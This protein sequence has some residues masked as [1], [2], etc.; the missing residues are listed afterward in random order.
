MKVN[1]LQMYAY[2]AMMCGYNIFISGG[3]GTGKTFIVKKFIK[4]ARKKGLKIMITAPTG[5]A[6]YNIGGVTLHHQFKP[7]MGPIY[8]DK[9]KYE[10]NEELL[11]TDVLVIDEISM[12]RI[13]LFDFVANQV[14][15]ASKQR[16]LAGK[17]RIQLILLG[18]FFQLPPVIRGSE[19]VVLDKHYK[20]DIGPGYCFE[21]VYWDMFDFKYIILTEV[22][23][24]QDAEFIRNL[25]AVRTGDISA[26]HYFYERSSKT[27]INGAI[28]LCGV[29]KEADEI[30]E[31]ELHKLNK[32][33][34]EIRAVAYGEVNAQDVI[35]DR[36]LRLSVGARVM[37]LA[38]SE[39]YK[40]GSFGVVTAINV[41]GIAIEENDTIIVRLDNGIEEEIKPYQW[42]VYRYELEDNKDGTQNLVKTNVGQ[43]IQFPLKLAYAI[44]I[45]KSQGQTYDAMNLSP[46]SWDCGQLYTA[47]SRV[48]SIDKLYLNYSIDRRYVAVSTSV[49]KFNNKVTKEANKTLDFNVNLRQTKE[50]RTE[51]SDD[52]NKVIN[53]IK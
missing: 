26:I 21:S 24:Q 37:L 41:R 10:I 18:D 8:Q 19:K 22:V 48:R 43:F 35:A 49:I 30:N 50:I 40:N 15:R 39:F 32:E 5:L 27:P 12:C 51:Y 13:D 31:R 33:I 3:A 36:V 52:L 44:T 47:L 4:D 25:N 6:A 42:D 38:N 20:R 16:S 9:S 2:N 11:E 1:Y 34:S 45:H 17:P 23:R 7:P 14:V 29:N 28:T 53:L 46:Y